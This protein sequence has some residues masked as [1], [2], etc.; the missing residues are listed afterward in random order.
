MTVWKIVKETRMTFLSRTIQKKCYRLIP[1][2]SDVNIQENI[3]MV[4]E[5]LKVN[6][7]TT[8]YIHENMTEH[9][10]KTAA[11]MFTYLNFCPPKLLNFFDNL[12]NNA[13]PREIL[14]ALMSSQG[15]SIAEEQSF[16]KI[17]TKSMEF[18]KLDE[19]KI[20]EGITQM[21]I[22]PNAMEREILG[23]T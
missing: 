13:S 3:N 15:N 18:L 21:N 17:F 2:L 1:M 7:T 9:T 5:K 22:T 20:L 6:T 23:K 16:G 14:L 10:L 8:D 4:G 11:E 12:F 19:Y